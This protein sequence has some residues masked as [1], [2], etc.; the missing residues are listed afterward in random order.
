[1]DF[2]VTAGKIKIP[3][4]S[5]FGYTLIRKLWILSSIDRI[6]YPLMLYTLYICIG[7]WSIGYIIEDNLGVIFA[8]GIIT[9]GAFLPGSF[10]YAYGSLQ[11]TKTSSVFSF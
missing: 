10:T 2:F 9:N 8:W 11:V 5:K 6:F 1:M 3:R 4:R 7:P